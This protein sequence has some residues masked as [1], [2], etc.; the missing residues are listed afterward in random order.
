MWFAPALP[1]L[2]LIWL[3]AQASVRVLV[4]QWRWPRKLNSKLAVASEFL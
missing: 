1:V 3:D 2:R 4:G